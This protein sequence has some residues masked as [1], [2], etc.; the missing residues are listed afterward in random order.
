LAIANF[1][2]KNQFQ[3]NLSKGGKGGNSEKV[4]KGGKTPV[5]K[6]TARHEL[7]ILSELPKNAKCLMD[8][9]AAQMLHAIQEQMVLL[10]RDPT[11]KIPASFD[12]GLQFAKTCARYTNP[13]SVRRVLDALTSHG[14][15]D[16]EI[17]LIANLCPETADEVFALVP[18]L[19]SKELML[20]G[21][22][23]DAL[24]ELGKLKQLV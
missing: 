9:E 3:G 12:K 16:D 13:H 1:C 22:L 23:M 14:V 19:K 20:R 10:S 8:C 15:S 17:C 2:K 11:I 5:V 6:E 24:S 7:K 21:R 4:A 18:S